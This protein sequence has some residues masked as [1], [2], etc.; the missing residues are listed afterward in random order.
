MSDGAPEAEVSPRCVPGPAAAS[1]GS[2]TYRH[3]LLGQDPHQTAAAGTSKLAKSL[4]HQRFSLPGHLEHTAELKKGEMLGEH[5]W[6]LWNGRGHMRVPSCLVT[7]KEEKPD[8]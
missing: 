2:L 5:A 3:R 4:N 6:H 1:L 7:A 8:G